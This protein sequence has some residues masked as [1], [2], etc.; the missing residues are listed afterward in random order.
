MSDHSS[1]ASPKTTASGSDEPGAVDDGDAGADGSP[2]ASA[3]SKDG[4]SK[5]GKSKDGKSNDGKSE[6]GKSKARSG[7][8]RPDQKP[9]DTKQKG[10]MKGDSKRLDVDD[11]APDS[12]DDDAEAGGDVDVSGV[13]L[14]G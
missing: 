5:D 4:Q 12:A 8:L 10:T 14:D 7:P 1:E 9:E 6:D 2:K 3:Q 11:E 13:G